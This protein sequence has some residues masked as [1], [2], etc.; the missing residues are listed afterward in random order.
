V[1][2]RGGLSLLSNLGLTELIAHSNEDYVRIV[3]TLAR[4]L[5]RFAALRASLRGRMG[6]SPLTNGEQ[7]GRHMGD[8]YRQMWRVD[9][10]AHHNYKKNL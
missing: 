8:A 1:A 3:T 9:S 5:P 2:G 7:F 4:D 6:A 10:I